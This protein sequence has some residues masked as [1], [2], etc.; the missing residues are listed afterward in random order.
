M[1]DY[2]EETDKILTLESNSAFGL[3][4]CGWGQI[5]NLRDVFNPGLNWKDKVTQ[6]WKS[7]FGEK[8]AVH[9]ARLHVVG[10]HDW[11]AKG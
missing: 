9:I 6:T 2:D 10:V 5:G 1:L 7:R 8:V 3:N 4:G 11:L